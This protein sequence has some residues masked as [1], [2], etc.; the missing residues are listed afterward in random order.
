MTSLRTLRSSSFIRELLCDVDINYKTFIQPIFIYEDFSSTKEVMPFVFAGNLDFALS[1]IENDIKQGCCKFL[2]F[3][4]P[5]EKKLKYDFV[6]FCVQKIKQTFADKALLAVDI[7]LCSY[8]ESGHCGILDESGT[9]VDNNKSVKE[10]L[11]LS[12]VV[13]HAGADI[14][15]P[16]DMMDG[17][18]AAIKN[19]ID[20]SCG[21]FQ[22]VALMSYSTKLASSFYGPFRDTCSSS[23]SHNKSSVLRDRK[24][25]QIDFKNS[26][27]AI[28]SSIRDDLEGAD[29]LMVKPAIYYL[30]L[31]K[32]LSLKTHKPIAAYH[33]SG[34]YVSL[35][36]LAQNGFGSRK[37]FHLEAWASLK[38]S[39]AG[40]I[41]SYAA[42]DAKKWILEND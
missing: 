32:D 6:S 1:Q 3:C 18:I 26:K 2:I 27:D 28:L 9:F 31:I 42:R 7:C 11:N 34:E 4:V 24:T 35:E 17:R 16:S 21:G 12:S 10:L 41:V 22:N 19:L 13:L 33:V 5:S 8:T 39:G 23:C 37:D 30:D 38:R 36:L 40:P 29:V 20:S 14:L 25:Y 15:A